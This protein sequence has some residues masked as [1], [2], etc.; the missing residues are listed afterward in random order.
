MSDDSARYEP[1]LPVGTELLVVDGPVQASGYTWWRVAPTAVTLDGGVGDGWVAIADHDGTPWVSLQSAPVAGLEIVRASLERSEGT[2]GQA[3]AGATSVNAFGL[4]LYR[5]LLSDKDLGLARRGVVISP[6]SIALALAMARAGARGATAREMDEV[7]ATSGW[8]A[9]GTELG[10]L[11]ELLAGESASWTDYEGGSHVL[12]LRI[13]NAA[14]A[15]DGFDIRQAY[16]DGIARAFGAGL[17]LVDYIGATEVARAAINDWV[18]RQTATRIPQLLGPT[19]LTTATRLVLV[20]AIYLKAN[21][22]QEFDPDGTTPRRFTR[23]DGSTVRVPTM[24]RLGDQ[25]V[26]LARGD[27]W[28]ATDLYYL[29]GQDGSTPLAMTIIVP[30][31]L[32]AFERDLTPTRLRTVMGALQAER[33]RLAKVT[34]GGQD[35][36]GEYA[37]AVRL[38][39]PRFGIDTR[40]TLQDLLASLGMRRATDP[41]GAD[42]SGITTEAPLYIAKV[43]H[44][45]NIDVDEKGTEAAAATAV[46]MDV[47]GCTRPAPKR[48]V[49]LRVDRPFLF[50]VRDVRTGAIVF[51]GRVLDPSTRG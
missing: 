50:L 21:W 42:F 2:V 45:A 37:Y 17:G 33:Q 30:D 27:G 47:G 39:L 12:A 24:S 19:D 29:G 25:D 3:R 7:L 34:D 6:T 26:P 32:R 44:Q 46:G 40:A 16:L 5:A 10:A 43:I 18:S 4:R 28:R 41:F 38:S 20:N 11:E 1:L 15:Q 14:F 49:P 22:L 51:M 13:A 23:A 9:L 36:C 48:V 35:S 31:R 8:G